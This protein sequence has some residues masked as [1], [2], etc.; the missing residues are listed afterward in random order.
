V[1]R[2]PAGDVDAVR[3][4]VER[5][6]SGQRVDEGGGAGAGVERDPAVGV[7]QERERG[8]RDRLLLRRVLGGTVRDGE[9]RGLG[10]GAGDGSAVHA[11]GQAVALQHVEVATDGLAGDPELVRGVD[12]AHS[13]V[14]AE[15]G[16]EECAAFGGVHECSWGPVHVPRHDAGGCRV[17][18]V[19]ALCGFV[20]I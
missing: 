7:G 14:L 8:L 13:A 11:T 5:G 6:V 10:H 15:A 2:E 3:H 20:W 12:D 18:C 9:L 16:G 1:P 19:T 4:G 17:S